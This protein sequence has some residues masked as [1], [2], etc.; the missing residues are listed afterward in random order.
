VF[1]G[2][3]HVRHLAHV[4]SDTIYLG[5]RRKIISA[6]QISHRVS[7]HPLLNTEQ[8]TAANLGAG[9]IRDS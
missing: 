4:I 7:V 2:D 1:L 5:L 9:H 8:E 6:V 3:T